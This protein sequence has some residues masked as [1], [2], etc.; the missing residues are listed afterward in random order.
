MSHVLNTQQ[1]SQRA[2]TSY[3]R[4]RTRTTMLWIIQGLL[5]LLFLFAGSIKLIMPIGMLIAQMPLPLPGSFIHFIG[6][7]EI[8]GALGLI[9]PGLLRIRPFLT[10]LAACGLVIIMIG[11]TVITLLGGEV[12]PALF[13]LLVG[14]LC[15]TVAYGRRSW[16]SA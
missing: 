7:A 4:R 15:A 2:N 11:A 3:A 14:L 8:A 16:R 6:I 1:V 9:L 10:T 13:P 12:V 5:A